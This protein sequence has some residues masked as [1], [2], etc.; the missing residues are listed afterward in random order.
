MWWKAL[1][2][3]L[4]VV[5]IGVLVVAGIGSQRWKSRTGSLV[6][7]LEAA[8]AA[9]PSQAYDPDQL[10]GLPE[11]VVRYFR[12]VLKPGQPLVTGAEIDHSGTFNMNLEKTQ[13]RPFTSHQWVAAQR[14][15]FVWNARISM[16]PG[17]TVRVHDAYVDG[18]GILTAA[19]FGLFKVA[20]EGS[21]REMARD[22]FM[23]WCMESVWYPTV[24]LPGSGVR[25]IGVDRQHARAQFIDGDLAVEI[26]F[27][28]NSDNLIDW[29]RSESRGRMLNGEVS[30]TPWEGRF[31]NY[32][33]RQDLLVPLNGDVAWILP[34]GRK[35][36]W[37]GRI[38]S[39]DY[40]FSR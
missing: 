19:L 20:D 1:L 33:R 14:P 10:G 32:S 31:W 8:R 2:I 36:Y 13:W 37:Q 16:I 11:P 9:F 26:L 39:L 22:E 35:T 28:F 30:P 25:W 23:R 24:L 21:T 27:H 7:R 5:V 15:G 29:A 6:E 40:T 38:Q 4:L 12:T 18:E 34:E 3:V 17:L